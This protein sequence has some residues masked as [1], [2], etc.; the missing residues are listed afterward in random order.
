MD[1]SPTLSPEL[2][3]AGPLTTKLSKER[4]QIFKGYETLKRPPQRMSQ[5]QPVGT[6]G[7]LSLNPFEKLEK[8]PAS[9]KHGKRTNSQLEYMQQWLRLHQKN[10]KNFIYS[11]SFKALALE[12]ESLNLS[13]VGMSELG[14]SDSDMQKSKS[15]FKVK[16]RHRHH[17]K[18]S[19]SALP[20][21]TQLVEEGYGQGKAE[22]YG[23]SQEVIGDALES[24]EAYVERQREL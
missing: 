15:L 4:K 2:I 16:R 5:G 20:S 10:N 17:H 19:S 9:Q 11:P 3:V 24:S 1:L 22:E 23:Q 12:M 14:I 8:Q 18:V 7:Y 13:V 6:W 21:D